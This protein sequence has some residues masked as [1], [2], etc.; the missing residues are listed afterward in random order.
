MSYKIIPSTMKCKQTRSS[1]Y[2]HIRFP[3]RA[4]ESFNL[5]IGHHFRILLPLLEI[6]MWVLLTVDT[7]KTNKKLLCTSYCWAFSGYTKRFLSWKCSLTI[8]AKLWAQQRGKKKKVRAG[9]LS[10]WLHLFFIHMVL[11]NTSKR[12]P[13]NA[14][15]KVCKGKNAAL[16]SLSEI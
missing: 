7:C 2:G 1:I 8:P 6:V 10:P 9:F 15:P 13:K 16:I 11:W 5:L 4:C 12:C 3:H 14:A